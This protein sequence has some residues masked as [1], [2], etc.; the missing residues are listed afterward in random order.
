MA[1]VVASKFK[2]CFTWRAERDNLFNLGK[3]IAKDQI[4]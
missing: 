3:A 1:N 2:T 4:T